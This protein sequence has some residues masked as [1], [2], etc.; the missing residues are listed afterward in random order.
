MSLNWNVTN[1][2]NKDEVCFFTATKDEPS[3]GEKKG[4]QYLHPVTNALIWWTMAVGIGR[5][6]KENAGEFAVRVQMLQQLDETPSEAHVTYEQV[7]AHVGLVTNVSNETRAQFLKK[8]S[9]MLDDRV[10]RHTRA[11]RN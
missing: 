10:A 6:T 1:V 7:K 11:D 5:I 8:V 4:E 9:R 3:R 2:A